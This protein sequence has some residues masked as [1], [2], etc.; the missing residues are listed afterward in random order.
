[1]PETKGILSRAGAARLEL[2]ST[3]QATTVRQPSRAG[4]ANAAVLAFATLAA[5]IWIYSRPHQPSLAADPSWQ[6]PALQPGISA[7][8]RELAAEG[9]SPLVVLPFA[10]DAG[11]GRSVERAAERVTN[12]LIAELSRV[13]RCGSSRG[14][15]RSSIATRSST[16]R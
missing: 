6:P 12:D 9:I 3:P 2:P 8:K 1:M 7:A 14:L 4:W 10:S 5:A 11:A 13:P 16:L 15:H